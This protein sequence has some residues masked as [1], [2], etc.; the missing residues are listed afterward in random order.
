MKTIF[1]KIFLKKYDDDL[2]N[3]SSYHDD[4]LINSSSYHD[5]LCDKI[6]NNDKYVKWEPKILKSNTKLFG[7]GFGLN[8]DYNLARIT[9][10]EIN[11]YKNYPKGY[12][13]IDID[14]KKIISGNFFN[15]ILSNK[16]QI[17]TFGS[18][19]KGQLGYETINKNDP[20]LIITKISKFYNINGVV[21]SLPL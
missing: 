4:D 15:V 20:S 16:G 7:F 19:E 10:K 18:N 1:K 3:S 11:C 8:K 14:I 5:D 12:I 21:F 2:I 13:N 9:P 17:Y 6:Y